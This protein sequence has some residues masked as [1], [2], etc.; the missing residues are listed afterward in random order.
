MKHHET[1]YKVARKHL[2]ELRA[3]VKS[4]STYHSPL[5]RTTTADSLSS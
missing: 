2:G 3:L 1:Q 5:L 4:V